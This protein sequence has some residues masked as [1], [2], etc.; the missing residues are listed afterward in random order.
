MGAF[1]SRVGLRYQ[2]G[3]IGVLGVA[4]LVSIAG[5]Y[6]TGNSRQAAFQRV[7]DEAVA[8]S[9]IVARI[10]YGLLDAR[11]AE[12]DFLLRRAEGDATRHGKV[13]AEIG[14]AADDLE[15]RLSESND[16]ERARQFRSARGDLTAYQKQFATVAQTARQI[17]FSEE[18]GLQGSLRKAVHELE[19][20]LRQQQGNSELL[21]S[22]LMM[23]RHEKDFLARNDAKYVEALKGQVADFKATLG[24][25]MLLTAEEL[26][27]FTDL[28]DAYQRDFLAVAEARFTLLGDI[29]KL[30][31][32]YAEIEPVIADVKT[33]IEK[34]FEEADGAVEASRAWTAK[35]IWTAL[36]SVIVL[37]LVGAVL[38]GESV[39]R[40]LIRLGEVMRRLSGGDK[41]VEIAGGERRD[42]AGAMA[43][44]VQ[45]FKENMIEADRLRAEQ[46]EAKLRAA[47]EQKAPCTGWRRFSRKAS[48]G[49]SPASPR[50]QP[51]WKARRKP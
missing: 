21:I 39:A 15:R 30:S 43:R 28:V 20:A 51:R 35:L 40:P 10:D 7:A 8:I 14:A 26:A 36:G 31:E 44:A 45:V 41:T 1:L 11:R 50:R 9:R 49:S 42:E 29:R 46:E 25:S 38:V 24:S 5:V 34:R 13:M 23:R 18:S 6:Y 27:R 17:G 12:K 47:A 2:I 4:G 37:V 33:A 22:V 3:A 32:I 19:A 16:A 48:A